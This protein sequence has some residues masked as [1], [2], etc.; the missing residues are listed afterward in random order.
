[1]LGPE[2]LIGRRP[3]NADVV[4]EDWNDYRTTGG[5][6]AALWTINPH[7]DASADAAS[8][9]AATRAATGTRIPPSATTRSR[10][11]S[12]NAATT[13]GTRHPRRIKGDLGFAEL[14][15]TAI[16]LRPRDRVPVGQHALRALADRATTGLYGTTRFTTRALCT[17][18]DVQLPEAESLGLRGPADVAGRQQAAVDGRRLLRGRL[19]L[20]GLRRDRSRPGDD[21]GRMG[22]RRR[23]TRLRLSRTRSRGLPAGTDGHLL[24]QQVSTTRSS[25]RPSSAN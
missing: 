20:V 17:R 5:R 9:S 4:E 18:Y 3:T 16:L 25:R 22:L 7:W 11:S 6:L 10:A 8:T 24:L 19:R 14:S 1:M 13:T 23:R 12:T 2:R 15:L 21:H